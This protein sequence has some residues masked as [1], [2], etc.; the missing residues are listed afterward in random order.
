MWRR[1]YRARATIQELKGKLQSVGMELATADG[2]KAHA[3]ARA[4]AAEE[5]MANESTKR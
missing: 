3:L 1:L 5:R 4:K 2:V